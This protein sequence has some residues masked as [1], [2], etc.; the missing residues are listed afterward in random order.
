MAL[1]NQHNFNTAKT[2]QRT[3]CYRHQ[4]IKIS[5]HRSA[6]DLCAAGGGRAAAQPRA[7]AHQV[8]RA[9]AAVGRRLQPRAPHHALGFRRLSSG[10]VVALSAI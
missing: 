1:M 3:C 7:C 10:A 2:V 4:G 6:P 5:R 9:L 8:G